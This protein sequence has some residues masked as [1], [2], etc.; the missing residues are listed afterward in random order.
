MKYLKQFTII[1]II[2]FVGEILNNLI[3]LPIPA[4]V[5]GFTILF[6][7]LVTGI[8]KLESVRET[9]KFLIDIMTIMFIPPAVGLLD[10][11][12][13]L[14]PI[15]MSVIAIILV[16]TVLVM[17]ITGRITQYIIRKDEKNARNVD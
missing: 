4:S 5:Y 13:V 12:I 9:G 11:W 6:I 1:I 10:S 2:S 14:K 7:C 17:A 3:P 8:V 16:T 15:W